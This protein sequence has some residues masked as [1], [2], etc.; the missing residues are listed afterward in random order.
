VVK[1]GL[2]FSQQIKTS[3]DGPLAGT[4]IV[5]PSGSLTGDSEITIE[6]AAP[7]ATAASANQLGLGENIAGGGTA[8]GISMK[9]AVEPAL[10]Y[11]IIL[12]VPPVPEVGLQ[13]SPSTLVI[14]YKVHSIAN[15]KTL[16]GLIPASGFTTT[17]GSISFTAIHFGAFQAAYT[18]SI[19]NEAREITSST[20]LQTKRDILE[21]VP[22]AITGRR[23]FVVGAGDDVTVLG[24]GFR[25]GMY[26]VLGGSQVLGLRITSGESAS[27]LAPI[28]SKFG[29]VDLTANQDGIE[30]TVSLLYRG[31][32]TD[33]PVITLSEPE[34]CSDNQ[35]YNV[36]GDLKTGTRGCDKA[37]ALRLAEEPFGSS[38]S[39]VSHPN[40]WQDGQSGCVTTDRFKSVDT[41]FSALS[42][43]DIRRG[44]TVGGIRGRLKFCK[45]AANLAVYDETVPPAK[46]GADIFDTIDDNNNGTPGVPSE[47]QPGVDDTCGASVWQAGGI[48]AAAK[49]GFCNEPDDQC[50]YDDLLTELSW[51]EASPTPLT[52]IDAL[53]YCTGKIADHGDWHLPTS[54]ELNQAA[55]DGIKAV[56]STNF[57]AIDSTTLYWSATTNS[58]STT[59]AWSINLAAGAG[60]SIGKYNLRYAT[61]VR[62]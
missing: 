37:I 21:L 41:D 24:T 48:D 34:V 29:L 23:P 42:S 12:A 58:A 32:K 55:I 16:L 59:Q 60:E 14:F 2:P 33:L 45:N 27:F 38:Q 20:P 6:E 62:R 44:K 47:I 17:D 57:L 22:F 40:C 46:L 28:Q 53:V 4:I 1:T 52:W 43:W 56:S 9:D 39:I 7:L 13:E 10:P 8:V 30:Q 25:E 36:D 54:K 31:I 15:K 49:I 19:V 3:D 18:K 5:F 51:S 50:T 61:C 26:M 11:T 35:Y